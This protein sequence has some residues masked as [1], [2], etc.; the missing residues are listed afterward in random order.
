MILST[1]QGYP[2]KS[3]SL[4]HEVY[5]HI[6]LW[7]L[8][9]FTLIDPY[10]LC[11][12]LDS[13]AEVLSESMTDAE[14]IHALIEEYSDHPLNINSANRDDLENFSF[15]TPGQIDSILES[16]PFR[17]KAALRGILGDQIYKLFHPF[18]TIARTP[19]AL[20]VES[21]LRVQTQLEKNRGIRNGIY[22]GSPWS[23]YSRLKFR[24]RSTLSGGIL[25]QKDSGELLLYDHYSGFLQWQNIKNHYKIILGNYQ[26]QAAQGLVLASAFGN[27][28]GIFP[29]TAMQNDGVRLLSFLS[30]NESTGFRGISGQYQAPQN[31]NFTC[32]YSDQIKDVNLADGKIKSLA[33][34]GYHRSAE[35]IAG[36]DVLREIIYGAGASVFLHESFNLGAL[37]LHSRYKTRT[38]RSISFLTS[39]EDD[40]PAS[41][42]P[43]P[44]RIYSIFSTISFADL[45]CSGELAANNF[46]QV[47]Q[48]YMLCY[49]GHDSEAGLKWWFI[50]GN[51]VS[52]FGLS[53]ASNSTFPKA[54]NGVYLAASTL[55][56][57]KLLV[58]LYWTTEKDLGPT[59]FDPMPLSQKQFLAQTLYS[60]DHTT[61]VLFRYRYSQQQHYTP[62]K[63]KT[64]ADELYN[65]RIQIEKTFSPSFRIRCRVEKMFTRDIRQPQGINI[66]HDLN[67]NI[68]STITLIFRFTSFKTD[69]YLVHLYEYENDLPGVFSTYSINGKGNKWYLLLKWHPSDH[70]LLW[71]KYR[72]LYLDGVPSIGTGYDQIS[73]DCKQEIRFQ[74][75]LE[76]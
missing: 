30:A 5:Q 16:R 3:V 9:I 57:P 65:F 21:V 63:L 50:P 66:F 20:H 28:K 45:N 25:T 52:P 8:L 64:Y 2:P 12:Q 22:T 61:Q 44:V 41:F 23:L 11:A 62:T 37:A 14:E 26:L 47:A 31:L 75:N 1:G 40:A 59:Y 74:I 53:F 33:S 54:K 71:I 69:D 49:S 13:L 68:L 7:F 36:M 27:S 17:Q 39:S 15:L 32:F 48:Q 72:Q 35:E 34:S 38:D 4:P 19:P 18:I 55:I 42:S 6:Y 43:D 51:Y 70:F 10:P 24:Y 67:W 73:G 60:P 58:S 76:Y 29:L 56:M 46:H